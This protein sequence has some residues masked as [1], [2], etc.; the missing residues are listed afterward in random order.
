M[1]RIKIVM[2]LSRN[3]ASHYIHNFRIKIIR[4]LHSWIVTS[5]QA[6]IHEVNCPLVL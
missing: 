6:E 5:P 3:T 2:M 4:M 1:H